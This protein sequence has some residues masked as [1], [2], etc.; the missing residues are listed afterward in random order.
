MEW[1]TPE[2]RD[3]EFAVMANKAYCCCSS[4]SGAGSMVPD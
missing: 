2:L 3:E 4:N 1:T